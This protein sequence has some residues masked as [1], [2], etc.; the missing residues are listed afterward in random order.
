MTK[1]FTSWSPSRLAKWE[2]CPQ[3]A[4]WESLDLLCPKC[5]KGEM[6]GPWK[7][8]QSCTTC[9]HVGVVAEALARGDSLHKQAEEAIKTGGKLPPGLVNVAKRIK[10]YRK[11]YLKGDVMIEESIVLDQNWNPVSKFTKG[12]WLRTAIDVLLFSG[13]DTNL[14]AEV[15]DWKSG[16]IDKRSKTVKDDPKHRDQLSVYST[17]VLAA[18]E[19]VKR[20]ASRLIF[21]DAPEGT[22]ERDGGGLVERKDL[23]KMKK[24]WADKARGLLTDEVFVPRPSTKCSW[25]P[26]SK[27]KGGPC[28]F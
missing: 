16:N 7:M 8:P 5:F 17:V 22:N 1:K 6:K 23:D 3:R 27:S 14:T 12:A 9:G 26:Y 25:C 18:Y 10:Q 13:P 19:K 24:R 2:E 28:V 11:A 20:V 4:K 21:L 15:A